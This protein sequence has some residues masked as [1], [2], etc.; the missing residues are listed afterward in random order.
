MRLHWHRDTGA[1]ALSY[2][3][4]RDD[5]DA[6][7]PSLRPLHPGPHHPKPQAFLNLIMIAAAAVAREGRQGRA[8]GRGVELVHALLQQRAQP[9]L[10]PR[11]RHRLPNPRCHVHRD[12]NRAD[13]SLRRP[14]PQQR[15]L[16]VRPGPWPQRR[17][18]RHAGALN[19]SPSLSP[20][21]RALREAGCAWHRALPGVARVAP[22]PPRATASRLGPGPCRLGL[23]PGPGLVSEA[24]AA[25]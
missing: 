8:L 11:R 6:T 15:P 1:T 16:H 25:A 9:P 10:C 20:E 19:V 4:S 14:R 17:E 12:R 2:N 22:S 18:R 24:C 21:A 23:A 13:L 7:P 5:R 3:T